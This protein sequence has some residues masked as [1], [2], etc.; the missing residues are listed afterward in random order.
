[1]KA[2]IEI[3]RNPS[4]F[5]DLSNYVGQTEFGNLHC[6]M[7]RTRDSD[8]LTESNWACAL[9]QLGGESENVQ[10]HRFGH[11]ACGW[12]EALAVAKGSPEYGIAEEIE[13]RLASYPVLDEGHFCE[14]EASEADRVWRECYNQSER[15]EY[16]RKFSDQFDFRGLNDVKACLRGEY[17]CGYASELIA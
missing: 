17:F 7:T 8:I 15:A 3:V 16:V 9:A 13:G 12:W 10:I 4:G 5:D 11:W 2:L 1:M 14:A 6:L